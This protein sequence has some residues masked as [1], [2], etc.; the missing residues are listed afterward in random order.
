[1]CLPWIEEDGTMRLA[2]L[3]SRLAR[4]LAGYPVILLV[5]LIYTLQVV[6]RIFRLPS[7]SLE[8]LSWSLSLCNNMGVAL[9]IE[10][11]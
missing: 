6:R 2:E 10:S 3:L 4:S 9:K 7:V 11:G 1:L 8:M 5:Q